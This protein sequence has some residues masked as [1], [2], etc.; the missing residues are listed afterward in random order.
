MLSKYL[1][2]L[3]LLGGLPVVA[4]DPAASVSPSTTA[5]PRRHSEAIK[6][7]GV[8][9]PGAVQSTN[10]SGYAVTGTGFTEAL[11][12]WIVP[13]VDCTKTY[14]GFSSNWIGINGFPLTLTMEQIG[15]DSGCFG[16]TPGYVSLTPGRRRFCSAAWISSIRHSRL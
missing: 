9:E 2:I 1:A 3:V 15:T 12:S 8:T 4:Q 13:K 16:G 10:W 6:L 11:G 7:Y 5:I 14:N